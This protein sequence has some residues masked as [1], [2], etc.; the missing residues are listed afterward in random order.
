MQRRSVHLLA[1]G[2]L[3]LTLAY[4]LPG[5]PGP[6]ASPAGDQATV[7][8]A[9][10]S[11][12][13]DGDL[14]LGREDVA[15]IERQWQ[16]APAGLALVAAP[17]EGGGAPGG[18]LIY[19][20]SVIYPAVAAPVYGL[21]GPRGLRVLNAG[22]FL[23]VFWVAWRVLG[24][25]RGCRRLPR[26]GLT[27]AAF[28]FVS[29]AL[30]HVLTLTPT[31]FEMAC[32]F[33]ALALWCAVRERPLW[34]RRELLPLAVAGGL[35]ACALASQPALGLFVVP[36]VVDLLWSRRWKGATAFV[37]VFV[38]AA[39]GLLS[40]Q[41]RVT[42]D[43]ELAWSWGLPERAETFDGALPFQ[44]GAVGVTAAERRAENLLPD[45]LAENG[46]GEGALGTL[47]A[48][49]DLFVGRHVGLVPY[50]PFAVFFLCLYLVDLGRPGGRT[51]HL[52]AAALLVYTVVVAAHLKDAAVA[53][54]A[55]GLAALAAVYPL[56]LFLPWRLRAGSAVLVPFAVAGLWT[57]PASIGALRPPV[58]AAAFEL[59]AREP[60]FRP[61][62]MEISLLATGRLP[63]YARYDRPAEHGLGVW[64]VPRE[65]FFQSEVNPAGVWVRGATRSEIY[66]KK[67]GAEPPVIH[68][69][70]RSISAE[71]VLTLQGSGGRVTVRF[72]SVAKRLG[73]PVA[74]EAERVAEGLW[75]FTLDTSEGAVP[76]RVNPE[77]ADLRYLGTFLEWDEG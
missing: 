8:G 26:S 70:A 21:L 65:T 53:P 23:L 25:P 68:F 54:A 66:V 4:A 44:V 72:D 62:P 49:R 77:S 36:P 33:L 60:A 12:W 17:E 76:A 42:G 28:F 14:E 34:G 11:L 73:T 13:E 20:C 1:A 59:H 58:P 40:A 31:A 43:L 37:V 51:R 22:L 39:V 38:L 29:A 47:R 55:P 75:R 46:S 61:L 15:R 57:L 30:A 71:N 10:S 24:Q 3:L 74:V 41:A 45:G 2:V 18:P 32:L 50:F 5:P 19:A 7:L 27:L 56:F 6:T 63:G 16:G 67:E 48:V 52:L 35:A 69:R 64:L 9:V